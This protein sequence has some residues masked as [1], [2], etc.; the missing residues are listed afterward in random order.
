[1]PSKAYL[2]SCDIFLSWQRHTRT[3]IVPS[4]DLCRRVRFGRTEK[5]AHACSKF[6]FVHALFNHLCTVDVLQRAGAMCRHPCRSM[7]SA[8]RGSLSSA[9]LH[10]DVHR[11]LIQWHEKHS[12]PWLEVHVTSS[13]GLRVLSARLTNLKP[14][15]QA[16][17]AG[18][19]LKVPCYRD[20]S[21]LVVRERFHVLPGM[22][23][24]PRD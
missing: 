5:D 9:R 4:H 15:S 19:A 23:Q 12:Q 1:M 16:C 14:L 22:I 18:W 24:G 6:L 11:K 7:P 17:R 10:S 3:R 21:R 13:N 2:K 8:G 20:G